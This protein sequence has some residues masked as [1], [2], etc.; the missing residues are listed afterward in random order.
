M[1]EIHEQREK[2]LDCACEVL[3]LEVDLMFFATTSIFF[4]ADQADTPVT[5]EFAAASSPED[6]RQR[7]DSIHASSPHEAPG[8]PLPAAV[9][10]R[11]SSTAAIES[12]LTMRAAGTWDWIDSST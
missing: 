11:V 7:S 6:H 8:P 10:T 12:R 4:V 1:L 3:V 9:T 2:V 5:R